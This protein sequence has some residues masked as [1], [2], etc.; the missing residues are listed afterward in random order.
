MAGGKDNKDDVSKAQAEAKAAMADVDAELGFSATGEL[1]EIE[2]QTSSKDLYERIAELGEGFVPTPSIQSSYSRGSDMDRPSI[3]SGQIFENALSLARDFVTPEDEGHNFD[4][5]EGREGDTATY[6]L[7]NLGRSG[8]SFADLQAELAKEGIEVSEEAVTAA[9]QAFNFDDAVSRASE[10][11]KPGSTADFHNENMFADSL[12][13]SGA[14]LA[15]VA[16]EVGMTEQQFNYHYH[17]T[18]RD[19]AL[20][21]ASE[22]LAL[23]TGVAATKHS[24]GTKDFAEGVVQDGLERA[25]KHETLMEETGYE[26]SPEEMSE[27]NFQ[28]AVD[29]MQKVVSIH[30]YTDKREIMDD[31]VLPMLRNSDKAYADV[32]KEMGLTMDELNESIDEALERQDRGDSGY[33]SLRNE[34][35]SAP[36][37]MRDES[38]FL[39]TGLRSPTEHHAPDHAPEEAESF[40]EQMNNVID[41]IRKAL[42]P[43]EKADLEAQEPA[44]ANGEEAQ[45]DSPEASGDDLAA[46]KPTALPGGNGAH[47]IA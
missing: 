12:E 3:S 14:T 2:M 24:E 39:G 32:A 36:E 20:K 44:E 11:V 13:A 16:K 18:F 5:V 35:S 29:A 33:H 46:A 10:I 7:D 22:S 1:P 45:K 38:G 28:T 17:S 25:Q 21:D 26:P 6:L 30:P 23:A 8:R 47:G 41:N 27:R 37:V 19:N 9:S 43:K 40:E 4:K 15:D 42:S 34:R 31:I